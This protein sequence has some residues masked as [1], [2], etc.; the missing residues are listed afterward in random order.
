[1]HGLYHEHRLAGSA[2]ISQDVSRHLY[3]RMLCGKVVIV[4]D[5]PAVMLSTLRKQWVKIEK[6]VRRERSS[7][8]DATRILELAYELPRI[9]TLLFAAKS[10]VDESNADV[11]VASIDQLLEWPPQCRTMYVTSKITKEQLYLV[12]AWMPPHS[13]VVTYNR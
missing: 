4:A 6:Q 9:Q 11:L 7:T 3:T 5:R 13:L 8:L 10:P 1:M 12:T 2:P